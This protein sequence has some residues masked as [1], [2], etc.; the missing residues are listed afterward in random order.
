MGLAHDWLEDPSAVTGGVGE[1]SIRSILDIIKRLADLQLPFGDAIRKMASD[2]EAMVNGLCELRDSGSGDTPQAHALARGINNKLK[3]LANLVSQAIQVLERSGAQGPAHTLAGRLDQA[4]KWLNQPNLDD[5][6]VGRQAIKAIIHDGRKIGQTCS[7]AQREDILDL[8]NEVESLYSQLEDLCD[9]GQGGSPQAQEIAR[10]LNRKLQELKK[11]IEKA[12]I[13]RVVNDFVD[14]ATPLKQFT[15]AVYQPLGTPNRDLNFTEKANNLNQFSNRVTSTARNV[16]S[17]LATNKRLAE[18]LQ[19]LANNVESLTPQ[20]ISAGR[21][22]FNNPDDRSLDEHFE[23]LKTQYQDNLEKLRSM[24]DEAVDS[25]NFVSSSGQCCDVLQMHSVD[26]ILC[27]FYLLPTEEAILK[28]T[29]MCENAIAHSQPQSMVE[30]ASN[31]ARIANR[32]VHVAKQEADN[33]EDYN[34]IASINRAA[35]HLQ[36]GKTGLSASL[37]TLQIVM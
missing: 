16:A 21:I 20:L 7:P 8:C 30:N 17:G 27:V 35:D 12:L 14:I 26:L 5:K 22:R 1:K 19:S 25:S 31:I 15:E 34:F 29:T 32:V 23:N 36:R 28:Y 18:G 24:V 9:R 2:I 4:S 13:D 33:S 10:R 11:L 37:L 3:E 6:N